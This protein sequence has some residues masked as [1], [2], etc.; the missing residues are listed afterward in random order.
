MT[1]EEIGILGY[2]ALFAVMLLMIY[3]IYHYF[4]KKLDEFHHQFENKL[5]EAVTDFELQLSDMTESFTEN[6]NDELEQIESAFRYE[7]TTIAKEFKDDSANTNLEIKRALKLV[8]SELEEKAE[9]KIRPVIEHIL[10]RMDTED[11]TGILFENMV[12]R[13]L[14]ANRF[15]NIETTSAS[16]DY[17]V[18]ILA[19][20]DRVT[21]AVQ[22]K[23]YSS[24]VGNKAVQEA[25]SGK[26]Y[27]DRMV[28]AVITNNEFTPNAKETAIKTNVILWDRNDLTEM[29][30][31][32]DYSELVS[33]LES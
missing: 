13:I 20:K 30:E 9:M 11:K 12:C 33:V 6:F 31:S 3:Y 8:P 7:M 10:Y 24:P 28:A 16:G 4:S 23:C 1:A 19:E 29:M 21:Y 22:C 18:D 2:I 14:Q 5:A 15:S 25:F 26:Q 17:G 32:M 27:Y